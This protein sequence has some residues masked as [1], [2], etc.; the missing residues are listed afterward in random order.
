MTLSPSTPSLDPSVYG[1]TKRTTLELSATGEL[2]IAIRRKSRFLRKDVALFLTK[3][4]AIKQITGTLP[5]LVLQAPLCSKAR[6]LLEQ[7]GISLTL[8]NLPKEQ[9]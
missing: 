7:Q 5:L 8:E 4:E 2:S 9:K 1:L 6:T 3:A